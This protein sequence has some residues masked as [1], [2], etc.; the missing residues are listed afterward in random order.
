MCV[1]VIACR[2]ECQPE[3]YLYADAAHIRI[4]DMSRI[5]FSYHFVP[6]SWPKVLVNIRSKWW[7]W[8][9]FRNVGFVFCDDPNEEMFVELINY[10]LIF[11]KWLA[12]TQKKWKLLIRIL[13]FLSFFFLFLIIRYKRIVKRLSQADPATNCGYPK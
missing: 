3:P 10:R 7:W 6:W 4:F 2:N 8:I 12:P 1:T 5:C 13:F 11:L 9:F